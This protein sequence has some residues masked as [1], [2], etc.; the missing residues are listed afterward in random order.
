MYV[1]ISMCI[2]TYSHTLTY[3]L[4]FSQ[5]HVPGCA[6]DLSLGWD[7][8]SVLIKWTMSEDGEEK[9]PLHVSL[10]IP[11]SNEARNGVFPNTRTY[12]QYTVGSRFATVRFTTI[13]FYDLC[14]VGTST[15]DL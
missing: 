15:P 14:P 9:L 5:N 1:C 6:E 8:N 13:H 11:S 10:D 4:C 12:V 2:C 3:A 7:T